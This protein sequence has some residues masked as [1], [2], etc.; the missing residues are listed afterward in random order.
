MTVVR[1]SNISR[2]KHLEDENASTAEAYTGY[3]E[4]GIPGDGCPGL[5]ELVEHHAT[6]HYAQSQQEG[7]VELD[8]D[9]SDCFESRTALSRS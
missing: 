6:A 4:V 7:G 2:G 3:E 1:L 8:V 9:Q 5:S